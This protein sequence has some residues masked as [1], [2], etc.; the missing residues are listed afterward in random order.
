LE[1]ATHMTISTTT[2]APPIA[3]ASHPT[4]ETKDYKAAFSEILKKHS[5]TLCKVGGEHKT[6]VEKEAKGG[7]SRSDAI[8]AQYV[9][10]NEE[11]ALTDRR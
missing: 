8:D 7:I 4:A 10:M 6:L 2:G 3:K 5:R 11:L 9:V 1:Q